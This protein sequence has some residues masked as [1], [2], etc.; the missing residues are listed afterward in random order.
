MTFPTLAWFDELQQRLNGDAEFGSAAEWFDGWVLIQ[1]GD[2]NYW[3]KIFMGQVIR[4]L[5]VAPPFGATFMLRG[6][7]EAWRE[8]FRAPK[9]IFR[10]LLFKG[11][12]RMEGN[13]LEAMRV[14]RAVNILLDTGRQI[15]V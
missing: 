10:E 14:T 6:A 15:G 3:L 4:L 7:E 8:L 13:L 9:N 1:I 11:Q 2:H 12:L 5:E